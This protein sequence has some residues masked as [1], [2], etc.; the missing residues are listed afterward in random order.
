MAQTGNP[1]KASTGRRPKMVILSSYSSG[2]SYG[3]LG[4]QMAATIIQDTS[5]YECIV[6]AVTRDNDPAKLSKALFSHFGPQRPI[7]GFSLLGGGTN[8]IS[9]AESMKC[10]GAITLLAGPQAEVDF[11]G[12]PDQINYP[13]RFIRTDQ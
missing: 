13:H 12:E 10:S 5:P 7:I 9:L 3:L 11:K 4:P 2:S 1:I 8:L 6:I